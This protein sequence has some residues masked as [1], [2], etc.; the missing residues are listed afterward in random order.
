M[1]A[2]IVFVER[3]IPDFVPLGI[4]L[5][6]VAVALAALLLVRHWSRSRNHRDA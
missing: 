1:I 2:K 3:E 6:A 5:L 4:A